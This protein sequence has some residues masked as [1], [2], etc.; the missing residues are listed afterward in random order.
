[1]GKII[2]CDHEETV[3]GRTQKVLREIG[4][5]STFVKISS[6]ELKKMQKLSKLDP[7]RF[8]CEIYQ[9]ITGNYFE[10]EGYS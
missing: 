7:A 5:T 2:K 10:E 8:L 4:I 3:T 1:M 6:K 9:K